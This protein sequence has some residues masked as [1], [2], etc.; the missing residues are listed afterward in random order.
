MGRVVVADGRVRRPAG[1]W[2][3]TVHRLLRHL[4]SAGFSQVPE[5]L[6]LDDGMET[7]SWIPGESGAAGWAR[8]VPED[9]LRAFAQFL[10]RYHEAA[11]GFVMIDG[12]RW[13]LADRAA[14]SDEVIC[15]GDFGPWNVVW[16]GAQPVGLID[17]DFAGPGDPML[18][19]AYAIEYTAPFR[20]DEV[21][22]RWHGFETPPDRR[23]RIAVF[24]E[25]YGLVSVQRLVDAVIER[26]RLAMSHVQQ[27]ADRNVEPQRT[28]V[29]NGYVDELAARVSWSRRH[30][31]L[32]R[33][34]A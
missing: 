10:R 24:A 8:V 27:L 4:R 2:T 3:P 18:D 23:H 34:P 9:G 29:E 19:V 31:H 14:R 1:W 22:M 16:R 12:D 21:A 20:S 13:A 32:L 33:S 25:A 6:G 11:S 28:W 15:H 26:Q 7:L 17:F 5:P 30:R